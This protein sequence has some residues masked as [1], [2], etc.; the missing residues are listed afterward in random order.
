MKIV[1]LAILLG[2]SVIGSCTCSSSSQSFA[3][4]L[5]TNSCSASAIKSNPQP[6]ALTQR[7]ATD[8]I[9]HFSLCS[10]AD[11]TVKGITEN[12]GGY[13]ESD[14]VFSVGSASQP[15]FDFVDVSV[16]QNPVV[17]HPGTCPPSA[18][19]LGGYLEGVYNVYGQLYP[20]PYS[21]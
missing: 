2:W 5:C 11:V 18:N 6:S 9:S 21:P 4:V 10:G 16:E 1:I 15:I 14:W 8:A 7:L 17:W 19:C 20:T 13:H 3:I 12:P